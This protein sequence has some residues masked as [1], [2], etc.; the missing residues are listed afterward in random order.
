MYQ[1][2]E[3]FQRSYSGFPT[4]EIAEQWLYGALEE[5]YDGKDRG[6]WTEYSTIN[7]SRQTGQWVAGYTCE[8]TPGG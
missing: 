2:N 8:Y 3:V 6:Q 1:K 4:Q 5:F 7:Q